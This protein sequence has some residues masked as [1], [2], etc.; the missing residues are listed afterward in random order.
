[1]SAAAA[2]AAAADHELEPKQA[3]RHMIDNKQ[4]EWFGQQ[5]SSRTTGEAWKE[6]NSR[7]SLEYPGR[8]GGVANTTW[9]CGGIDWPSARL[10]S[11]AAAAAEPPAGCLLCSALHACQIASL[12]DAPLHVLCYAMLGCCPKVLLR[13]CC[14]L[15]S[16]QRW[17]VRWSS[18]VLG[19]SPA[20]W[21][22][23]HC[24]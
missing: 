17:F 4:L 14:C 5:D 23:E 19:T 21:Q 10:C 1:M 16:V 11:V 3:A 13:D 15:L 2:A 12:R 22:L 8:G 24:C 7:H 9:W 6:C 20:H 18:H